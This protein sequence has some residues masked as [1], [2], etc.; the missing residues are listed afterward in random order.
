MVFPQS[1]VARGAKVIREPWEES[2]EGGT[3]TFAT[4]QT[5]SGCRSG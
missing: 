1:A 4:V 3:V 2:D 5:V